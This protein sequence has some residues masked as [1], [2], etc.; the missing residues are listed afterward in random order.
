MNERMSD[1]L[2]SAWLD[3]ELSPS[4]RAE[5][6]RMLE[7]HAELRQLLD[8]LRALRARLQSLPVRE[9]DERLTARIMQGAAAVARDR[10][11]ARR[12]SAD[13]RAVAGFVGSN[14]A[15]PV[16]GV[17]D[18]TGSLEGPAPLALSS[19]FPWRRAL[20]IGGALA[21][22]LL[23]VLVLWNRGDR[24]LAR[25]DRHFDA[26]PQSGSQSLA[27][28][29]RLPAE[30]FLERE[31]WR[32][33]LPDSP[34]GG[35]GA[36]LPAT[37]D[38]YAR[39]RSAASADSRALDEKKKFAAND[40]AAVELQAAPGPPAPVGPGESR[41]MR[42]SQAVE[43]ARQ[44]DGANLASRMPPGAAGRPAFDGPPRQRLSG[45]REELAELAQ[46][47]PTPPRIAMSRGT[48]RGAAPAAAGVAPLAE[49]LSAADQLYFQLDRQQLNVVSLQVAPATLETANLHRVLQNN[50][51]QVSGEREESTKRAEQ[52]NYYALPELGSSTS[53]L[54][55]IEATP[56]QV[57]GLLRELDPS[58]VAPLVAG[59]K[60]GAPDVNNGPDALRAEAAASPAAAPKALEA[61][62]ATQTASPR[63][64]EDDA[65]Q[66]PAQAPGRAVRLN[67]QELAKADKEG[68]EVRR[69]GQEPEKEL[70]R[71]ENRRL[72]EPGTYR[73]LMILKS[74]PQPASE[75]PRDAADNP[76]PR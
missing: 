57:R 52:F 42:R 3:D 47:A 30:T 8:E 33:A 53:T 16:E 18:G 45:E 39:N 4:E 61:A 25:H 54:Y 15:S 63:F 64:L 28:S 1:E 73:L 48:S 62:G 17:G 24:E 29:D 9:P 35:A 13:G 31:A 20:G 21:A 71:G 58:E 37:A 5:V 44:I 23:L 55:Y 32:E 46:P 22:S 76:P 36:P 67:V 6:E 41:G 14:G 68:L 49:S 26:A 2:L 43:G 11:Q 34:K 66:S 38:P 70:E 75:V 74:P 69:K 10:A 59:A 19:R 12:E 72:A 65:A 60:A 56:E 40:A 7:Q 50:R 51:I 27:E